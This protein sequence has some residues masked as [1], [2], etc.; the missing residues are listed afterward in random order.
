MFQGEIG[1]TIITLPTDP[2]WTD[3]EAIPA[4]P[5]MS[6]EHEWL[7]NSITLD[8]GYFSVQHGELT[9]EDGG[10]DWFGFTAIGGEEYII[11]VESRM[12]IKEDGGTPYVEGKLVDPSILEI[13]DERGEQVTGEQDGGGFI[14]LWAW[15]YFE[16]EEDGAYRIEMLDGPTS[17]GIWA[18]WRNGGGGEYLSRER[19]VDSFV[20]HFSPGAYYFG[21]GTPYQSAG[22]TGEY[23]VSLTATPDDNN[24]GTTERDAEPGTVRP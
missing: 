13:V 18:I 22:N 17:V 8:N 10:R 3:I 19:P 11:E 16:P 9:E 15:G 2:P 14:W 20:D 4:P 6:F 7:D 23:T 21:V 1:E 24:E 12:E 5:P